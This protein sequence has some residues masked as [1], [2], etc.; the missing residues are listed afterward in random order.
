MHMVKRKDV[1]RSSCRKRF[2]VWRFGKSTTCSASSEDFTSYH[3]V[4]P[5]RQL[6][7][8][9]RWAL[10]KYIMQPRFNSLKVKWL[11]SLADRPLCPS[12][13]A[14]D[15][16]IRRE[17]PQTGNLSFMKLHLQRLAGIYKMAVTVWTC[18]PSSSPFSL[19]LPAAKTTIFSW[20][21]FPSFLF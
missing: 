13:I 21:Q 17:F 15:S 12:C 1:R 18:S 7:T 3:E 20:N 16:A 5:S 6:P 14:M 19:H 4:W 10:A 8:A 2:S 11:S 9:W